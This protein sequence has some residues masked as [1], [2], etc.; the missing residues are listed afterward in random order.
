MGLQYLRQSLEV[1]G[2]EMV[3]WLT[4]TTMFSRKTVNVLVQQGRKKSGCSRRRRISAM[5]GLPMT[6]SDGLLLLLTALYRKGT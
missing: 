2:D 1:A 5:L 4:S 3:E 6:H